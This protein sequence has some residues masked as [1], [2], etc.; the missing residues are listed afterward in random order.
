MEPLTAITSPPKSLGD[1]FGNMLDN[2]LGSD[3]KPK[4]SPRK[5]SSSKSKKGSGGK[6]K[7][8]KNHSSKDIF[9]DSLASIDSLPLTSSNTT[10]KVGKGFS[11]NERFSPKGLYKESIR[12][13]DDLFSE[14][15]QSIESSD[16]LEDSILGGLGLNNKN[17]NSFKKP[18][19]I[20]QQSD[21]ANGHSRDGVAEVVTTT[22]TSNDDIPLAKGIFDNA[23]NK[24]K[25]NDNNNTGSGQDDLD[26]PPMIS[27]SLSA[28]LR[29]TEGDWGADTL[30][31]RSAGRIGARSRRA[32][33]GRLG[34]DTLSEEQDELSKI[35]SMDKSSLPNKVIV[36]PFAVPTVTNV[37]PP[38]TIKPIDSAI[39][40]L[41][42]GGSGVARASQSSEEI[43]SVTSALPAVG[44]PSSSTSTRRASSSFSKSKT[45]DSDSDDD[46]QA[47]IDPLPTKASAKIGPFSISKPTEGRGVSF[48]LPKNI[49]GEEARSATGLRADV[50]DK[51]G[52]EEDGDEILDSYIPSTASSSVPR[53]K[54]TISARPFT[55]PAAGSS[56]RNIATGQRKQSDNG[57]AAVRA[58]ADVSI[59]PSTAPNKSDTT[60]SVDPKEPVAASGPASATTPY[61]AS[62]VETNFNQSQSASNSFSKVSATA[63]ITST[64]SKPPE[65]TTAPVSNATSSSTASAIPRS[66]S[67]AVASGTTFPTASSTN[68]GVGFS[69]DVAGSRH[70]TPPR[71]SS[72]LD[73]GLTS[74]A[75]TG[76]TRVDTSAV[77]ALSA[78]FEQ[79]Q[80]LANATIRSLTEELAGVKVQLAAA[81]TQSQSQDK[82]QTIQSLMAELAAANKDTASLKQKILSLDLDISRLKDE[83]LMLTLQ[84]QEELKAHT[85][86]ALVDLEACERRKDIEAQSQDRRHE[87]AIEALKRIHADEIA[88]VKQRFKDG[89]ALEQL[90]GQINHT[91]GAIRLI[92]EQLSTR[93]KGL[94]SV[95]AGQL[96]ARE[97]L[98]TEMEEKARARAELAESEGYRL[99]GLLVHMEHMVGS[100]RSQGGEEKERLRLEHSR[101]EAQQISMDQERAAL[102]ER[103]SELSQMAKA[104]ALEI[105]EQKR[106]LLTERQAKEAE[107]ETQRRALELDKAN[108]AQQVASSTSAAEA[109]M[110]KLR[111]EEARLA[112]QKEEIQKERDQLSQRRSAA[113][114]DL[115]GAEDVM[116]AVAAARDELQQERAMLQAAARELQDASEKVAERSQ[117][118]DTAAKE[119]SDRETEVR[120]AWDRLQQVRADLE[121]REDQMAQRH[122]ALE[123]RFRDAGQRE[124]SL[125]SRSVELA[126]RTRE[127]SQQ[128]RTA[129][130]RP[131]P[132]T[133]TSAYTS[134][135]ESPP[136]A[137][138][139][140]VDVGAFP[141]QSTNDFRTHY[142]VQRT[143]G[144]YSSTRSSY[145]QP[146]PVDRGWGNAQL[147]YSPKV[148]PVSAYRDS[149]ISEGGGPYNKGLAAENLEIMR[150][151]KALSAVRGQMSRITENRVSTES[152]LMK[153][154]SFINDLHKY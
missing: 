93:Q 66:L 96:D 131:L 105:Q 64:S 58:D 27:R 56:K 51:P 109:S 60:T 92:E 72:A 32:G 135:R 138:G 146:S 132:T 22:R 128:Q 2:I 61:P 5:L 133:T 42:T 20:R 35:L 136:S 107:I 118:L 54:R 82:S 3:D 129:G 85:S 15:Q 98:L 55:A 25:N 91:T 50:A 80:Q 145:L 79:S 70:T 124:S 44:S 141:S 110:Q 48:S 134:V 125:V 65:T 126:Q 84:H 47:L 12:D 102:H 95:K 120:V 127:A 97:R 115:K 1:D 130:A 83:N 69:S 103:E 99:K 101:L 53:E 8:I 57:K 19:V 116:K 43:P 106:A 153:E 87:E 94:E 89:F 90:A 11:S 149:N 28:P 37:V 68:S 108:F 41:T 86:R 76:P 31:P 100:L 137:A 150:A 23:D 33:A 39:H 147:P 152:F 67:T 139:V 117:E 45:I 29:E 113:Q 26:R 4:R 140:H 10:S 88:G 121:R 114:T 123:V 122:H 151:K 148:S 13:K 59:R 34:Q 119:L 143:G 46:I 154:R 104:K 74:P 30:V 36:D 62:K 78:A 144:E 73:S 21:H 14:G 142:G 9:E 40:S 17:I 49:S 77:E 112:K 75:D 6:S 7:S 63:T 81:Q 24:N 71:R 38:G 16:N 111:A 52:E 18:A